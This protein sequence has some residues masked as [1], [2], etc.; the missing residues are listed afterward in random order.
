VSCT[1][2]Q[3]DWIDVLRTL[4]DESVHL[5]VTS[6]PYWGNNIVDKTTF[7]GYSAS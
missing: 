4:P 2:L 3:G 5:V 1:I 6:P 7:S